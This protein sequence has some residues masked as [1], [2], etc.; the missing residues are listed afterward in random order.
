MDKSF[1]KSLLIDLAIAI[2]IVL[3]VTAMIKPTIV[4]GPSMDDTLH[5]GNYLILNKLAY[6]SESPKYGDIVVFPSDAD[7][8]EEKLFIKR[9]IGVGGDEVTVDGKTVYVNGKQLDEPYVQKDTEGTGASKSWTVPEGKVFVMGDNRD[10]SLDS[11]RIGPIDE[12]I[13]IGK[14]AVRLFPF[15]QIGKVK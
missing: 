6:R 11:R 2:A 14:V 12:E 5:D 10:V 4:R 1:V 15:D 8:G 9:V 7:G 13:I 3:I